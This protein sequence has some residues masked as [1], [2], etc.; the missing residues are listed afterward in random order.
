VKASLREGRPR[1]LVGLLA[2]TRRSETRSRGG[3]CQEQSKRMVKCSWK[4][5]NQVKW[6]EK[7]G[8]P[9]WGDFPEKKKRTRT[10]EA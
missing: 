10:V 4:G 1:E 8:P 7:K 5:G 3:F 6:V 2:K 9:P